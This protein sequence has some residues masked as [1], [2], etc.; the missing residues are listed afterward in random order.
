MGSGVS[1][2][3]SPSLSW[4]ESFVLFESGVVQDRA[5][6]FFPRR[7]RGWVGG[8]LSGEVEGMLDRN[9]VEGEEPFRGAFQVRFAHAPMGAQDGADAVVDAA[10]ECAGGA[11]VAVL[12]V[13]EQVALPG[14]AVEEVPGFAEPVVGVPPLAVSGVGAFFGERPWACHQV[15]RCCCQVIA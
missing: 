5:D 9:L 14:E 7:F 3:A 6:G 13:G 10:L 1:S 15:S 11:G 4:P 2:P 12:E 8:F